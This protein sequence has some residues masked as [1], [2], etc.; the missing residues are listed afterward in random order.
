MVY[1]DDLVIMDSCK[2]VTA[3]FMLYIGGAMSL[4]LFLV[5]LMGV[6]IYKL[7]VSFYNH[8]C[9]KHKEKL[10]KQFKENFKQ[11]KRKFKK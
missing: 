6:A 4:A 5:Y 2:D 7:S 10:D 11:R 8:C 3:A 1:L 9:K